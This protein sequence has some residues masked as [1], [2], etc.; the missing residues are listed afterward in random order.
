MKG[1]RWICQGTTECRC[2]KEKEREKEKK[3]FVGVNIPVYPPDVRIRTVRQ[4]ALA[5]PNTYTP[6]G[7]TADAPFPY[8]GLLPASCTFSYSTSALSH[9]MNKHSNLRDQVQRL[10][11]ELEELRLEREA[12][13]NNVLHFMQEADHARKE[14]QWAQATIAQ[15]SQ[16]LYGPSGGLVSPTTDKTA[17]LIARL[18]TIAENDPL[19]DQLFA[20]LEDDNNALQKKQEHAHSPEPG[21]EE[22]DSARLEAEKQ[23][24]VLK[25]ALE[26]VRA[27]RDGLA[28]ER[29]LLERRWQASEGDLEQAELTI[30]RLQSELETLRQQHWSAKA[31]IQKVEWEKKVHE[32]EAKCRT[33]QEKNDAVLAQLAH[34]SDDLAVWRTKHDVLLEKVVRY[35]QLEDQQRAIDQGKI[36][37]NHLKTVNKALRDELRKASSRE[38]IQVNIEYLRN[39]IIKFLEKKQT[40]AQLIPVLATLLQCSQ[41]EQQRLNKL[42]RS[43]RT[44]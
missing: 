13:K 38:N 3:T 25:D 15:L 23:V 24:A 35:K 29:E 30:Q 31:P 7:A 1:Q 34:V 37:E 2:N 26:Q 21:A 12:S 39:V 20:L 11:N 5:P 22:E 27:E 10:H 40:R 19:L 32:T 43:K 18:H 14:L 33:L 17:R 42:V 41:D 44:P 16:Q 28:S 8:K 4:D 36:R 9:L 6:P